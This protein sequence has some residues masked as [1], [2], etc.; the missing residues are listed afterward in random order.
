MYMKRIVSFVF[1]FIIV[2]ISLFATG[3]PAS[4]YEIS[5]SKKQQETFFSH[6]YEL[7]EDENLLILQERQM[8]KNTLSNNLFNINYKSNNFPKL[9]KLKKN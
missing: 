5:N 4:Y 3:F 7:I 2:N 1:F 9:L 8:L 6:L